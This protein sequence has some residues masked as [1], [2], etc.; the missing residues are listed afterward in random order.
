MLWG[1]GV[2]LPSRFGDKAPAPAAPVPQPVPQPVPKPVPPS[3]PQPVPFTTKEALADAP[4]LQRNAIAEAA[5]AQKSGPVAPAPVVAEMGGFDVDVSDAPE[6][7]EPPAAQPM[8]KPNQ[9]APT[10]MF[11]AA[12]HGDASPANLERLGYEEDAAA[13]SEVSEEPEP[14]A[15]PSPRPTP[16]RGKAKAKPLSRKGGKPRTGFTTSRRSDEA[17]DADVPKPPSSKAGLIIFLVLL[18]CGAGVVGVVLL[19]GK[20]KT[21]S[22]GQEERGPA[23]KSKP[24][25]EPTPVPSEEPTALAPKPALAAPAP[26]AP[27]AAEKPAHAARPA[28][29]KPAPAEKPAHVEKPAHAEKAKAEPASPPS[30]P[31]PSGGKPTEDDFRRANEAYQRGNDKLFKGNPTEAIAEFNQALKLNPKDPASHRGLGLAYAQAGKSA[32]AVKQLKLYLKASPKANDR[33]MIEK[34][35]DQL[36]GQ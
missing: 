13:R 27:A 22:A 11:E 23:A 5:P 18:L 31:K 12:V 34:K 4:T 6:A 36:K 15:E 14:P 24:L 17:D 3:S 20:T 2:P 35:L 25:I 19:R 7:A 30:E 28:A 26:A 10:V 1:A 32:D 29:E 8:P 9:P 16:T 21:E 33:A